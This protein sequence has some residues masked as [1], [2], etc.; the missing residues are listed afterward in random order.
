MVIGEVWSAYRI[1]DGWQDAMLWQEY[2]VLASPLQEHSH[3]LWVLLYATQ[4]LHV[5]LLL[6]YDVVLQLLY[7]AFV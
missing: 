3:R 4:E 6:L 5:L 2:A 1:C 7:C